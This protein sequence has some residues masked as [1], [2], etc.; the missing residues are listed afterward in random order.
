ME[1][2]SSDAIQFYAKE[3]IYFV[4]DVIKAIPDEKQ[5][6]ILRSLRDYP[7]TSVR[8]G[9]GIGKSA[10][11]AWSVIWFMT[12]RPFPKIPCTAPTEHQLM[13]VL[14]AEISK[15]MRHNPAFKSELVW[16]KEKLYMQGHPEEWFAVPRTAT[17][18]EALQGFHSDHVLYIIDEASGV[19]DKV[20]EPVLGAMT[21][22]DAKLLMM[23]NPTR[24]SGFFYDSHHKARGEYSAIHID[25]RDSAHVSKEF[26][27]KIIKMFGED[28]DVFRVRV[29]GQFPKAHRIR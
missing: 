28:S 12:T 29:A 8:S 10:V 11:E 3:P 20:F 17:N 1:T 24:L 18:P 14:W 23:G 21:G 4:E 25:G 19:S 27:Q 26:I 13:D 9:H 2:L 7:M 5:R 15:W 16:T 22:S 6:M